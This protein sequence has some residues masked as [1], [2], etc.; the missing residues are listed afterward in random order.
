MSVTSHRSQ[1]ASAVSMVSYAWPEVPRPRHPTKSTVVKMCRPRSLSGVWRELKAQL[2]LDSNLVP[3]RSRAQPGCGKQLVPS[4]ICC[5]CGLRCAVMAHC[6]DTRSIHD[7]LWTGHRARQSSILAMSWNPA[8]PGKWR[9]GESSAR[10][11]PNQNLRRAAK[12]AYHVPKLPLNRDF[13]RSMPKLC[14]K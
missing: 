3:R 9:S 10:I 14:L 11:P 6:C 8:Q 5:R 2:H 13:L 1:G 4:L 7:D 12:Y